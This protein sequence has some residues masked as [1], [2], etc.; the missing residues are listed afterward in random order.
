VI[1]L[2]EKAVARVRDWAE[3]EEIHGDAD[4]AMFVR[5]YDQLIEENARLRAET[6]QGTEARRGETACGLDA[7]HD[8]PVAEGDAPTPRYEGQERRLTRRLSDPV[9]T[10]AEAFPEFYVALVEASAWMGVEP[11]GPQTAA[12]LKQS[13]ARVEHVLARMEGRKE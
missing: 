9:R 7:K 12:D 6:A 1:C 3:C 2:T 5:A 8:G 13:M 4:W 10:L 11:V